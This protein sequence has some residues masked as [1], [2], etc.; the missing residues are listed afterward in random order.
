MGVAT[1]DENVIEVGKGAKLID[2]PPYPAA[3][4]VLTHSLELRVAQSLFVGFALLERMVSQ[5]QMRR[6]PSV[7]EQGRS[8]SGAERYDHFDSFAPDGAVTLHVG[9]ID[10][11]YRFPETLFQTPCQIEPTK[12]RG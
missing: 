2:G 5:L 10:H 11:P 3:P 6:Q 1:A 4:F 8:K 12:S 9:V 7:G